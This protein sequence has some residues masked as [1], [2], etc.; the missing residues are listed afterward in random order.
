MQYGEEDSNEQN[1]GDI[2]DEQLRGPVLGQDQTD[3]SD[4]ESESNA[5]PDADIG[6]DPDARTNGY[7]FA[8]YESEGS[9]GVHKR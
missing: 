8:G 5:D 7:A 1:N 2:F 4:T 3:D 6:A 9:S